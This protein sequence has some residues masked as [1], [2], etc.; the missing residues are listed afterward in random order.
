LDEVIV[1]DDRI[2]ATAWFTLVDV[3][4]HPQ[5]VAVTPSGTHPPFSVDPDP[6]IPV[7]P[8]LVAIQEQAVEDEHRARWCGLRR[9]VDPRVTRLVEGREPVRE[10]WAGRQRLEE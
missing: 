8:Q 2:H 3:Q 1:V 9:Y 6:V 4:L 5:H 10:R 7:M